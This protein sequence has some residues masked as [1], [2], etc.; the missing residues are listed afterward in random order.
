MRTPFDSWTARHIGVARRHA[1]ASYR[2]AH[3]HVQG[4]VSRWISVEHAVESA[5]ALTSRRVKSLLNTDERL[6]PGALYGGIA[7]LSGAILA[8]NCSL[9]IRIL[10]P[11]VFAFDAT[12]Y[13]LPHTAANVQAYLGSLEDVYAPALARAHNTVNAHA[14]IGFER[15]GEA[16]REGRAKLDGGVL[17]AVD[18]AQ[19]VTGL[20]LREALGRGRAEGGAAKVAAKKDGVVAEAEAAV[21]K[22]RVCRRDNPQRAPGIAACHFEHL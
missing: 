20:K 22:E 11:S 2:S 5:C 15:A 14:W 16:V 6:T 21:A 10:L 17:G 18:W 19:A 8:R 4:V 13:F 3:A 12:Y 9:P 1:T 7:A